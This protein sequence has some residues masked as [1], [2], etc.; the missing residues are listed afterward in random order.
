MKISV[1]MENTALN[2]NFQAEHG[3][4]LYLET[5][6]KNILFDSGASPAFAENALRLGIDLTRVDCTVLSHGHYD[7]GGG[8]H[9][10]LEI[11]QRAPI[12]ISR[13]AF[14]QYY[15]GQDRY[16]G[17]DPDLQQ[18]QQI[19]LTQDSLPL[20]SGITLC[21][22]QGLHL[23]HSINSYGLNKVVEEVFVPDDFL[24]EQYLIIEENGKRIVFSGC[25]HRG[26]LN[27]MEWLH[28]DVL[29]GGFHFMKLDPQTAKGRASLD[30]AAEIL[31]SYPCTYYT[32]HCTGLEQYEYLQQRM[33]HL[34]Y[35]AAG[36]V[37]E[38]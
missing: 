33:P 18:A 5:K 28:P 37:L 38:L 10:F 34:H 19:V 35:L 11:N 26:I 23:H 17:L 15:A 1:L 22:C 27:I 20:A 14:G 29:I 16:I 21:N 25:S 8:L 9:K 6:T 24:H 31:N 2:D 36:C 4:S 12:Y 30:R 32:C 13:Q 3:L 7:H